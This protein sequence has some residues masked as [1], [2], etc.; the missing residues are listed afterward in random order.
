MNKGTVK[1]L[2]NLG[3]GEE[4]ALFERP[5]VD[6]GVQK[7]RWIEYRAVNQITQGSAI[8]FQVNGGGNYYVDLRRTHLHVSV[9]VMKSDGTPIPPYRPTSPGG[10]IGPV[11]EE[12]KVGPVNLWMHSIFSQVDV[13]LQQKL[14]TSSNTC[15]FV[16]A[17]IDSILKC[18]SSL[19]ETSFQAQLYFKD[20]AGAMDNA[21]PFSGTNTG[22][23]FRERY[24]R[25]SNLVDMQGPLFADISQLDR[26]LLN[27]VEVRIKL[28]P[29]KPSLN[30]MAASD[31]VQYVTVIEDAILKVCH[32]LPMPQMLTAHQETLNK[33][34]LALYPYLKSELKRF[35]VTAG[36]YDFTKDD[37]FQQMIP[38]K[39]IVC[40]VNNEALSGSYKKNP[41][42][43]HHYNLSF[44]E[45][46]VDG[47]SV[48]GRA[49]Q[50]KF[51]PNHYFGNYIGAYMAMSRGYWVQDIDHA[52][53]RYD[54]SGGYA[55]FCFDLEP[56]IRPDKGDEDEF[57]PTSKTGNLRVEMHFSEALPETI[58]VIMY[59]MFPKTIAV[60]HTRSVI[61]DNDV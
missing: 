38:T 16:K 28:W 50:T 15:Y 5:L 1:K 24:T 54:F 60:H 40:M 26:Y 32:V 12:A 23:M 46:S 33:K 22:L 58:S 25:E 53:T 59:G 57:W 19:R 49:L 21:N 51:M 10:T 13:Y 43:F 41:F 52:I 8:E 27:G 9:R 45:V 34:H 3:Y 31:D 42:N 11:D 30:L 55:L 47:E 18:C 56:E 7:V 4:L 2:S 35:T 37:I 20:T 14:V 61:L 17:Y 44:I 29:S 6:G 39:L 48:P 36:V